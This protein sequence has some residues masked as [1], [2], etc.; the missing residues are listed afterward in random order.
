VFVDTVSFGFVGVKSRAN[1]M[2]LFNVYIGDRNS[3]ENACAYFAERA[4]I[5]TADS[6]AFFER[7]PATY[8]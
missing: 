2:R 4:F 3:I 1:D 8:G 5:K 7:A 6:R